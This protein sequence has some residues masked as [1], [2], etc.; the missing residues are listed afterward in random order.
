[1]P[2]VCL[3]DPAA[4]AILGDL[5]DSVDV[6]IWDGVAAAP[7]RLAQAEFWAPPPDWAAQDDPA[8]VVATMPGLKV[9]QL[10]SAGVDNVLRYVPAGVTLCDA[11]GVHGGAVAEWVLTA[12]LASLRDF[13]R[14]VRGQDA[15]HWDP[16]TTDELAGKRVLIVGAGDLGEQTARRLAPFGVH[17]TMSARH[18]RTAADG[19][20]VHGQNEL[21]ELLPA[22]DIV[23]LL[24]PLTQETTGLVNAALLAAMPDGALLVNAARGPVVDTRALL[25]ELSSGRLRAALD[26]TDPEP[27][28]A[29]HALWSAPN[30][31][32]TPHIAGN[33]VGLPRRA[34][35]LIGDQIRRYVAGEE[36]INVVSGDY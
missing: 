3:P 31:L 9:I 7:E 36:L 12:I 5:P 14:F 21:P 26:V 25:A 20:G 16:T 35:A 18:A 27:L 29:D 8:Q 22:A 19:G 17:L 15:R 23:V 30:L 32:I 13:P 11:R 6:V 28:P 1:M 4:V 33:V 24:V 10:S 2:V 34:N